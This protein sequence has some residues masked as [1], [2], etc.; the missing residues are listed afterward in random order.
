M[1]YFYYKYCVAMK[2][3]VLF[4]R[5]VLFSLVLAGPVH[6]QVNVWTWHNDNTRTGQ[7]LSETILTTANV[8]TSTFGKLFSC[9]LDRPGY[10]YAEPLYVANLTMNDGNKH[11]VIFVATQH[12]SAYLFDA[13]IHPCVTYWHVNLLDTLHGGTAGEAP[14]TWNDVG[15]CFGDL[16]LNLDRLFLGHDGGA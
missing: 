15:E 16:S 10:V 3:A 8:N 4:L 11:N 7:N 5:F 6:G 2:V 12:D 14:I 13:D 9:P 1:A